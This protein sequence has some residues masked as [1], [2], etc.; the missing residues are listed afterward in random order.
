ML[1]CDHDANPTKTSHS[2]AVFFKGR[3]WHPDI[4]STKCP[5]ERKPLRITTLTIR[6]LEQIVSVALVVRAESL[7]RVVKTLLDGIVPFSE[8]R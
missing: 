2:M 7:V 6:Q 5:T 4:S 1:L 8:P 3:R